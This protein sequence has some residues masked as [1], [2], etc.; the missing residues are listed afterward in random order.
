MHEATTI[1]TEY[2]SGPRSHRFKVYYQRGSLNLH[3]LMLLVIIKSPTPSLVPFFLGLFDTFFYRSL[4]QQTM[5]AM[6][7]DEKRW[8]F[9]QCFGDKGDSDDITEGELWRY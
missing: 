8:K 6:N 5:S 3:N 9:A 1:I 2:D 4:V 7:E